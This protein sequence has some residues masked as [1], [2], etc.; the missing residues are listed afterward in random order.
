M[1]MNTRR[2]VKDQDDAAAAVF[3]SS[4]EG[5]FS[6]FHSQ[7]EKGGEIMLQR[8]VY[9]LEEVIAG[10]LARLH[11]VVGKRETLQR[12]NNE[13]KILCEGLEAKLRDS[14]EKVELNVESVK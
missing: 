13:L 8:R 5:A 9:M 12:E 7:D 10:L 4:G 6:G 3:T 1:K 14:V 2:K 11:D